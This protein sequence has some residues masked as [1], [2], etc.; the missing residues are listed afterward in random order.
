MKL[1]ATLR[2]SFVAIALLLTSNVFA[3]YAYV[4][5]VQNSTGSTS[6]IGVAT[7]NFGSANTAGN[8]LVVAVLYDGS[9]SGGLTGLGTVVSDTLGNTYTLIDTVSDPTLALQVGLYYAKNIAGGTNSVAVNYSGAP[10]AAYYKGVFAA[11]Y[12]GLDTSTPFTTG[13]FAGQEQTSSTGAANELTSGSTPSLAKQPV[14][15]VGFSAILH[16]VQGAPSAGTGFTQRD[17]FWDFGNAATFACLEDK[18]ATSTAAVTSTFTPAGTGQKF[19][20]FVA[21]FN[22]AGATNAV[23][24]RGF[25]IN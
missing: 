18:R 21:V 13:Q 16:S 17:Q 15:V 7:G 24:S 5:D 11:E 22:E 9:S 12:S 2:L 1:I 8:L 4:Q 14:A 3:A 20:T 19:V 25:W 23:P 6:A 10:A